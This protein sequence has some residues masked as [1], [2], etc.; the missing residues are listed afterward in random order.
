M[1]ELE[2]IET[3]EAPQAVGPYSQGIQIEIAEKSRFKR[4]RVLPTMLD[5]L[6]DPL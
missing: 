1:A 5:F 4:Y 6:K 3:N 2:E